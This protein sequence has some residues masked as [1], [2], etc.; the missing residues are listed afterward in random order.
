MAKLSTS[1]VLFVKD[2]I[3]YSIYSFTN[4]EEGDKA[5]KQLFIEKMKELYKPYKKV[6]D[7]EIELALEKGYCSIQGEEYSLIHTDF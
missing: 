1:N 2:G 4:D 5:A 7:K 6:T 3:P